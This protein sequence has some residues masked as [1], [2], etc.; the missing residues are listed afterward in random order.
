MK[1]AIGNDHR[2]LKLKEALVKY[3]RGKGHEVE[4]FGA[5]SDESCDYP[6]FAL[7]VAKSVAGKKSDKGILICS[8]GVGMVMAASTVKGIRA[9]NCYNMSIA[10]Y[11][12]EHND[13]NLLVFGASFIKEPIAKR[14]LNTWLKTDFAGGRH[15]RRVKMFSK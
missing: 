8:S 14:M 7:K 12:R 1:I 3:L 2:G 6:E 10:R 11:S 5:F 4:D 13:A 9:V 15:D